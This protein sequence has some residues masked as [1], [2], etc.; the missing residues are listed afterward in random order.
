MTDPLNGDMEKVKL[1]GNDAWMLTKSAR[2]EALAGYKSQQGLKVVAEI[3][4]RINAG[5]PAP[6]FPSRSGVE[7]AGHHF[8]T[9]V[10]AVRRFNQYDLNSLAI[11]VSEMDLTPASVYALVF[12]S[13]SN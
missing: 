13:G 7:N 5:R 6:E 9:V 12:W 3:K 8:E 1:K 11:A 10:E 4:A 2:T